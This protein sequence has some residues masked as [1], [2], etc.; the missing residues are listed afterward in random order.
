[1]KSVITNNNALA[2]ILDSGSIENEY[3]IYAIRNELLRAGIEPWKSVDAEIF[4]SGS[5]T[6]VIAR[7][8][9]PLC[10]SGQNIRTRRLRKER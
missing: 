1:M 9:A 3:I 4:V 2:V 8:S 5:Q 6:L 7:P 10:S